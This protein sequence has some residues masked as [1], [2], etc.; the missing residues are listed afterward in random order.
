MYHKKDQCQQM[1]S[2]LLLIL[3]KGVG[4][5]R[6]VQYGSI[7]L[8][9]GSIHGVKDSRKD[10]SQEVLITLTSPAILVNKYGY[11][12]VSRGILKQ[13]LNDALGRENFTLQDIFAR[14]DD[15]ER[16]L[17][18]DVLRLLSNRTLCRNTWK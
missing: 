13:Y 7:E 11:P 12:Q 18:T 17:I 15:T 8:T 9:L 5:S 6:S 1:H 3:V 10:F 16:D 2:T 4:R 14:A